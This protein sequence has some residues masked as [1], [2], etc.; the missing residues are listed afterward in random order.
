MRT[1][2]ASVILLCFFAGLYLLQGGPF[3]MPARSD[4]RFGILLVGYPAQMLGAGLIVVAVLGLMASRQAGSS[5]GRAAPQA[6]QVRFFILLVLALL[7]ITGA[8][9]S[10]TPGP[11]PE[12][13]VPA[14]VP[15]SIVEYGDD[16]RSS[17]ADVPSAGARPRAW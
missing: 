12:A 1:F 6:W 8:F 3:F 17:G 16:G 7:L 5:G 4:P 14:S 15:P 2:L 10:G 13:R 11:N 9:L